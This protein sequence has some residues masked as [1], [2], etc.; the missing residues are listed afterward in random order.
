[1]RRRLYFVLPD[2]ESAHT[3]ANDLLL[4]RVE[5]RH[6]QFLARRGTDLGELNEA[7]YLHKTDLFRGAGIGL[8]FGGV[9]GS[10]LGAAIVVFPPEGTQPQLVA[11]LLGGVIG[12][13]LGMWMGSLAAMAVPNS[14]LARFR[15]QIDSGNVLLMV[16]VPFVRVGEIRDLVHTKHPEAQPGGL[17][18]RYPAFP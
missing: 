4:A 14:R 8:Q 7:S 10:L 9:A 2:L 1:M 17:D 13:I 16:D 12:A 15:E 5:D 18:T 3:T 6:M 11:V